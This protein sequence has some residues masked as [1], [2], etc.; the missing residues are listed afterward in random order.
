VRRPSVVFFG[1]GP[2]A[3]AGIDVLASVA[4]DIRAV[5]VPGNRS[6]SDVDLVAHRAEGSAI[7]IH[8]QPP[9]SKI[10]SFVDVLRDAQ[11]EVIVV[12]SYSMI[13]PAAVLAIPRFGCVNVH[14][15]LLPE[16][17]GG[18]VVQWALINGERESGVTLH[19][20]D[21]GIDTGPIIAQT[22]VPIGEDDDAVALRDA[23]TRAGRGLL[24]EMWPRIANGTAP[25]SEQDESRAR[26]W[27]LRR[28]DQG[29]IAPSMTTADVCRLVRALNA[30]RPGAY[31]DLHGTRV[32]VTRAVPLPSGASAQEGFRLPTSDGC[33]LVMEASIDGRVLTA[34]ELTGLRDLVSQPQ[35]SH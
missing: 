22:R 30:N 24:R 29:C 1:Y 23:L 26:Y 27:P 8:V 21:E 34:R 12:W 2:A 9:K 18:H 6:G 5:V 20:I 28:P 11:A 3:V 35:P 19:Y 31:I 32:C 4:A 17:R 13:L 15:G 16:Y 14:A 7:P 33:V 25:R 10:A